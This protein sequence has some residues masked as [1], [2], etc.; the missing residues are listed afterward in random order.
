MDANWDADADVANIVDKQVLTSSTGGGASS[1]VI[2][3]DNIIFCIFFLFLDFL[4]FFNLR[5][6]FIGIFTCQNGLTEETEEGK[7]LKT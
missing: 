5:P 3:K 2:L 7:E 1:S 4:I 6:I